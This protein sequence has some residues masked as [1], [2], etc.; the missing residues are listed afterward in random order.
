MIGNQ[1]GI[2][3]LG[4]FGRLLGEILRPDFPVKGFDRCPMTHA[5]FAGA[6]PLHEVAACD[7]V[8]LC[9]PISRLEQALTEALPYLTDDTTVL[10]VCSVKLKAVDIME[11]YLPAKTRMLP[12]HPMFG[13][14]AAANGT[15]GLPFVLCPTDRTPPEYDYRFSE[16]LTTQGFRVVRMSPDGHDRTIAY[17]LC[18]TQLIGRAL[19]RIGAKPSPSDTQSFRHLLEIRDIACND[20]VELFRDIQNFNPYAGEM[21][22]RLAAALN[23]IERELAEPSTKVV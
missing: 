19:D 3:G 21:R 22:Q 13:P 9:V 8:F 5:A 10:D 16:Y 14:D 17:S 4:R 20:T 7:T 6:A 18:M 23:D 15:R 11:R 12:T 2:I 1:I